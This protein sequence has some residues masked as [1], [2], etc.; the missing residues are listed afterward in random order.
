MT[1]N[2]IIITEE[3]FVQYHPDIDVIE[4]GIKYGKSILKN[5][6]AINRKTF[7]EKNKL[8]AFVAE[9]CFG[10]IF[11]HFKFYLS[12]DYDY[13]Y[14]DIKLDVKSKHRK[15]LPT[16]DYSATVPKYQIEEQMCNYYVF[17]STTGILKDIYIT[18]CGG[19]SKRSFMRRARFIKAGQID[20]SNKLKFTTDSY[21]I[22]YKYLE[23]FSC[24]HL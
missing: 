20:G 13:E 1:K 15:Y 4:E 17:A 21:E 18:Y 5:N 3:G 2:R 19:I 11:P 8:E 7:S 24:I 16:L 12:Y 22:K 14:R 9:Y 6:D 10:I 23:K